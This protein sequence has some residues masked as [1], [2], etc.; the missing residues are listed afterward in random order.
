M[1][2]KEIFLESSMNIYLQPSDYTFNS[3]VVHKALFEKKI[4][5]KPTLKT[6]KIGGFLS[7]PEFLLL[8]SNIIPLPLHIHFS[9]LLT[10]GR[11]T[12]NMDR[13]TEH[14]QGEMYVKRRDGWAPF[15]YK[16][17]ATFSNSREF[18][19]WADTPPL[20]IHLIHF[21]IQTTP[22]SRQDKFL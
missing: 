17:A 5:R 9:A 22:N 4:G 1:P 11:A 10:S 3:E 2:P 7:L 6:Q 14:S 12:L 19:W 15:L 18:S 13:P 8:P 16:M 20:T 21:C